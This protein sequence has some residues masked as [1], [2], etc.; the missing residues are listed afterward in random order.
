MKRRHKKIALIVGG[1]GVIGIAAALVLNVFQSNMVFFFSPTQVMANEAPVDRP[2][3]LGGLVKEGSIVRQNDGL[4][5]NFIVTDHAVDMPVVYVGIL[6]DLFRE[7]QGVVTQGRLEGGNLFRANEVLAKHDET[8]MPP[9]VAEAL[10]KG[11]EAKAAA[12]DSI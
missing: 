7:G 8:Y 4:T 3:R 9:E 2:F 1:V 5:V 6:P 10:E 11:K 12:N